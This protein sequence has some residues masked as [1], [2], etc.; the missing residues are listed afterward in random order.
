VT[1]RPADRPRVLVVAQD[2]PWPAVTGS[3][4]RLG[5]VIEALGRIAEI[6]LFCFVHEDR[7]DPC[8]VPVEVPVQR[9]ARA[10]YRERPLT[11]LRRARWLLS[12][13]PLRLVTT[14]HEEV[15]HTFD[16][17]A[18]DRYDLVWFSKA[19]TFEVLGRPRLG[20]TL[21]DVD[22]LEDRKIR[23]R[24]AVRGR[25]DTR[26]GVHARLAAGQALLDARRWRRM[27]SSIAERVEAVTVCSAL[28]ATRLG[29]PATVLPN[30][31]E[32]P[33]AP[34]GARR[35]GN[36][37]T[38]LFAGFMTYPPN[39]DA[40]HWLVE[41][42]LPPLRDH[43]PDVRIRLV[44]TADPCVQQLHAPPR[45]T[46][47]GRVPSMLPELQRADM[48][49]V[50]VRFGSGT[51]VKILEAFAHRLPVVSTNLG[52]EGLGAEHDRHL[53][54]ADSPEDFATA[55]ARLLADEPLRSR[56]TAEG[57][58][59]HLGRYQRSNVAAVVADLAAAHLRAAEP[60]VP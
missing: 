18:Q 28:D 7:D 58:R 5:A 57:A 60:E 34:A 41:A 13:A 14:D 48:V 45:V 35:T 15:R 27:Q 2:F 19:H 36:P 1:S 44:G 10:T 54:L 29:A 55:C 20:P 53:L 12:S 3:H 30:H 31:Y 47:V 39:A 37:P 11:A 6:E 56:L 38:V 46:V 21:V 9:V 25:H 22:D 50:P 17:W 16:V 4:I 24:V 26:G 33:A 8:D 23:A 51:R 40:A 49:A 59:L 52:A 43:V 42:V 32:L